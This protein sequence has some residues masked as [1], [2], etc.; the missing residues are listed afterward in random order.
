MGVEEQPTHDWSAQAGVVVERVEEADWEQVRAIRLAALAESPSAFGSTLAK[1]HEYG[2]EDWRDCYRRPTF[3]DLMFL[4]SDTSAI[5]LSAIPFPG[6]L[7]SPEVMAETMRIGEELCG[8]GRVFMQAQTNPSVQPV[9]ELKDSMAQIAQDFPI[10]AWKAYCHAG[11]PGWFLDD[12]DPDAPQ[13]GEAFLQQ[14]EALVIAH[15]LHIHS[16]GLGQPAYG[17]VAHGA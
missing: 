2:E 5:V 3:L 12:H 15:G 13:C 4:E 6:G 14:A 8:D 7:L 16:G 1:E 10:S 9:P 11:G 17:H